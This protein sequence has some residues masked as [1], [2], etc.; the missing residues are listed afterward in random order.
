MRWYRFRIFSIFNSICFGLQTFLSLFIFDFLLIF[1]YSFEFLLLLFLL[2]SNSL[3]QFTNSTRIRMRF[4]IWVHFCIKR[5]FIIVDTSP[6][7]LSFIWL[8]AS[9]IFLHLLAF[10][11]IVPYCLYFNLFVGIKEE[12]YNET[13]KYSIILFI[14][15][16]GMFNQF[17]MLLNV[18]MCDM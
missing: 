17:G 8:N 12:K 10:H 2:L 1:I 5:R 14:G 9:A 15:W 6:H 3:Y 11:H 4:S 16:C 18:L 13:K 7:Y